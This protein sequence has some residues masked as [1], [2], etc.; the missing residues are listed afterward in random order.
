M[1]EKQYGGRT[2]REAK[3]INTKIDKLEINNQQKKD[4]LIR[5]DNNLDIENYRKAGKIAKEVREFA[6]NF[7]KKDMALLEIAEKIEGKIIELNGKPAFPV[8]L[9]INE[10]AAHYTPA[11]N[12]E[13][14][15]DGLLKVDIGVQIEGAIADTAFSLD[16]TKDKKYEKLIDAAEKAL[17]EALKVVKNNDKIKINSIGKVIYDSI[18]GFGFSPVR[19]LSG[20]ELGEYMVHAG[21]TIPNYD[22]KN[23][24]EIEE[25]AYA[26]EPFA[27][28]GLGLVQDGKPGEIYRFESRK[29]VRDSLAR[30]IM[31]FVE[32]EYKTLPFCSRWII[33]KFGARASLALSLLEKAEIVYR[34]PLLVEKS[35]KEVSQAEHTFI[36]YKGKVEVTTE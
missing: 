33:K 7:I 6:R 8:N 12:D 24:Q 15:A 25:W 36:L 21:I 35:H 23:I 14:K 10:I 32:E 31:N 27:T 30:E 9:S 11:Y 26:I 22:N 18:V 28:S 16:L 34:Y 13:T 29:G 17:D 19:N 4:S 3:N 2:G 1:S 5:E 20:H